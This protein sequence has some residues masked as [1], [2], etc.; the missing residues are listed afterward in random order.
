MARRKISPWGLADH[1]E[2]FEIP[3]LGFIF[4]VWPSQPDSNNGQRN[5]ET[6]S[7]ALSS[8]HGMAI[9]DNFQSQVSSSVALESSR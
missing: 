6:T 4:F 7:V 8:E 9:H 2:P 5:V 3:P 1:I